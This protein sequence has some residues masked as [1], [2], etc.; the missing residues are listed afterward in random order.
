MSE[1]IAP[2]KQN[3]IPRN[4][5]AVSLGSLFTDIS[6]EMIVHLLPLFLTNVLGAKT[7]VVGLIEGV[8]ESTASL[9]R[10]F[11]G[12]LSDKLGKRKALTV[13]GYS[14]SAVA[15]P[16]L[17]LASTWPLVLL[18]RFFDRLGKGVRTA[19][20][21]ALVAD[22]LKAENRG[23]GFGLHRAADSLGAAIGL[24][25][26]AAVTYAAGSSAVTLKAETFH[27]VIWISIIPAVLG[28]LTLILLARDVPA[29]AGQKPAARST[30]E[31]P[32]AK[33]RI[34][35]RLIGFFIVVALFTLGNS[36]D[37]FL[38]LRAQDR[39]LSVF[40]VMLAILVFNVIYTLASTPA[41][42][43]SDKI[44]RGR[45]LVAGWVVYALVYLGF[46]VAGAAW[47]IWV[48]YAL[49]G[50]YYAMVEGTARAYVADL[51]APEHRGT[52]YGIYNAA[53]GIVAFPAS[54][55]AGILWEGVSSWQGYGASAPFYF[56]S[57]MA[58][59]AV[60]L[61]LFWLPRLAKE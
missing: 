9:T 13:F 42:L 2:A 38:V 43:R 58:I 35:P 18:L 22:S 5:L 51:S 45:V 47:H 27:L 3:R 54:L 17:L 19:P 26:A 61:T 44:G 7:A 1:N 49:Y 14:L 39:G 34:S 48:L 15:K 11:S 4:L 57:M 33:R 30:A 24:V 25:I 41:G 31:R 16:L 32:T 37:S 20:R 60:L 10:L 12:W 28:V 23:F 55:I 36:S 29:A 59:V 21:D 53:V 50:L 46:A 6:S 8:A 40:H 56:G 52:A